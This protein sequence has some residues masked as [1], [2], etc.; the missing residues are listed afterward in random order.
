MKRDSK[1]SSWNEGCFCKDLVLFF[2]HDFIKIWGNSRTDDSNKASKFSNLVYRELHCPQPYCSTLYVASRHLSD[3]RTQR[4]AIGITWRLAPLS[5]GIN[6][7]RWPC[8]VD[9]EYSMTNISKSQEFILLHSYVFIP[10][11]HWIEEKRMFIWKSL[12]LMICEL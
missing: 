9:N 8:H 12:I 11:L 3:S 7:G 10:R 4:K 2:H 1:S 6:P 5:P